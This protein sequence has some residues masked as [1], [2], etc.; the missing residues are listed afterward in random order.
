MQRQNIQLLE[1]TH[2]CKIWKDVTVISIG[3]DLSLLNFENDVKHTK[4]NCVEV[5]NNSLPDIIQQLNY[6]NQIETEWITW[7]FIII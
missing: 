2:A 7:M 5:Q 1:F 6:K 4:V 3:A